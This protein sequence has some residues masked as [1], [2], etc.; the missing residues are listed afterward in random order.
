[1][2]SRRAVLGGAIGAA[3]GLGVIGAGIAVSRGAGA[4]GGVDTGL[5]GG[6][7]VIVRDPAERVPTPALSGTL[8]SGEQFDLSRFRDRLVV[9]NVWASWCGPCHDEEPD[10]VA[11]YRAL[12]PAGVRFLGINAGNDTQANAR[13]FEDQYGVP[14]QSIWEVNGRTANAVAR[15][16]DAG[17]VVPFTFVLDQ[18]HRIAAVAVGR[19]SQATLAAMVGQ[20]TGRPATPSVPALSSVPS[21]EA[22]S[23]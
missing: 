14:F 5:T 13:A 9:V 23:P 6:A 12:A 18:R 17:A 10:L 1:M 4:A 11:A 8:L 7:R 3:V 19:V 21:G 2:T 16:T 22:G 20:V 15:A